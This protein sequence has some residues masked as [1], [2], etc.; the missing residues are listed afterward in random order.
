MSEALIVTRWRRYGKDRL[1]VSTVDGTRA[2]WHDLLSGESHVEAIA[3]R[4][5]VLQAIANWQQSTS[6]PI[7]E[8]PFLN[9]MGG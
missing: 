9:F 6:G 8:K 4:E 7:T 3:D 5:A 2:G 1:Y